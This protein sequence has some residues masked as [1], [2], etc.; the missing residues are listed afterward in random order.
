MWIRFLVT[1][2]FFNLPIR[3]W[4]GLQDLIFRRA[5]F[6]SKNRGRPLNFRDEPQRSSIDIH[7]CLQEL[8]VSLNP[9]E[10]A[11]PLWEFVGW[12]ESL[13]LLQEEAL[14][15]ERP[16]SLRR[17]LVANYGQV[18]RQ[19]VRSATSEAGGPRSCRSRSYLSCCTRGLIADVFRSQ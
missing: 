8:D 13:A 7:T 15:C 12:A 9:L 1:C 5:L 3:V 17:S 4:I 16:K 19:E 2:C 11:C 18:R 10:C 6:F 14:A